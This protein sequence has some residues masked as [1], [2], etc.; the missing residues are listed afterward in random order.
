MEQLTLTHPKERYEN[1]F[2]VYELENS[3][4][5]KYVF[6]NILNKISLPNDIDPA[7]FEYYTIPGNLPFTT[8]SFSIYGTISLWWLILLTNG[9]RNP[10]KLL[11]PG[12]KIKVI[13]REYLP[14]VLASIQ[15]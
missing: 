8:I 2:N 5:N 6:Y 9:I 12:T 3:N 10:T 13:K 7:V 14:I 11:A 1:I 15:Q 4:G